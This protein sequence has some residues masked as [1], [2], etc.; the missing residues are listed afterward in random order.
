MGFLIALWVVSLLALAVSFIITMDTIRL[1][2]AAQRDR[3]AAE[4]H[5]DAVEASRGY[6]AAVEADHGLRP[7][8]TRP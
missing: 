7:E 6:K 3:E 5:L 8:H 2:R 4:R 1:R